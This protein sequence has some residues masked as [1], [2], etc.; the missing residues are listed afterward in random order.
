VE[1]EVEDSKATKQIHQQ[2]RQLDL[3]SNQAVAE[4]V[5]EPQVPM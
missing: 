1:V 5:A 2:M 4:P 3:H